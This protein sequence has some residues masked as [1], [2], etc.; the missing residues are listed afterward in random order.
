[1]SKL[2]PLEIRVPTISPSLRVVGEGCSPGQG[3]GLHLSS[4]T[5]KPLNSVQ[6]LGCRVASFR[7]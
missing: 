4:P 7:V 3:L 1:M 6:G 2:R 5:A